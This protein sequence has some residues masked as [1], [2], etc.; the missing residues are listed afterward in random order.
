MKLTVEVQLALNLKKHGE[1]NNFQ[2]SINSLE[3]PMN[4]KTNI[5][6]TTVNNLVENPVL[7]HIKERGGETYKSRTR[8]RF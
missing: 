7:R 6:C 8:P 2:I 1:N 4:L 5:S 3:G